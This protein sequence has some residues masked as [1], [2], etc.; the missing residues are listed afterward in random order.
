[1]TID[2]AQNKRLRGVVIEVVYGRHTAQLS[3]ADHIMLWH[4]MRDLG[5]DVGENDVVTTLQDLDDR[6]Y[7][8]FEQRKNRWTNRAEISLIQLTPRGR[9]LA[10]QTISDPAI[11]F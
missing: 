3:R 10:E 11:Q 7:V 2:A 4:A 6:G 1:V 8:R 5:C 9:D